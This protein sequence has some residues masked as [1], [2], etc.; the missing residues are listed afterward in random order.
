MQACEGSLGNV[1]GNLPSMPGLERHSRTAD[2][3]H[4]FRICPGL[5]PTVL[6][7]LPSLCPLQG[8]PHPQ[9]QFPFHPG[10]ALSYQS[11]ERE[12]SYKLQL[13]RNLA[14]DPPRWTSCFSYPLYSLRFTGA[15]WAIE[16]GQAWLLQPQPQEPLA[17][18]CLVSAQQRS[19]CLKG[20]REMS[21]LLWG[22]LDQKQ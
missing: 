22:R 9:V 17:S 19:R 13:S 14:S 10:K 6:R 20:R 11:Q 18:R 16:Q 15:S 5:I 4:S 12:N 3:G 8:Q 21:F 1:R 2:R 7:I